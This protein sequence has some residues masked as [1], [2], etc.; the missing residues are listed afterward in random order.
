MQIRRPV[1]RNMRFKMAFWVIPAL[2][3]AGCG[4][5][6]PAPA[7]GDAAP[8]ANAAEPAGGGEPVR[9]VSPFGSRETL[10]P[11]APAEVMAP[12]GTVLRVRL[13]RPIDTASSKP[14][15]HFTAT[16]DNPVLEGA[17]VV[18]P[19]GTLFNGHLTAAKPSGRLRGRAVLALTLES[20]EL[21]GATHEIAASSVTR[22]G[23]D[24]KRRNAGLI[25]GGAG[26]G[27]VLGAIA[28]GAKGA[29]LGAGA[30]AAAGTAGAAASGGRHVRLPAETLLV[31]S[32]ERPVAVR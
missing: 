30:G 5:R 6:G 16:L 18:I 15:D 20:F 22:S 10:G 26:L 13:T 25:G 12:A 14:G 27:A 24:H 17:R 1:I 29:L 23:G 2:L 31:F 19:R 21:R 4:D 8:R 28:G 3:A 9:A 7:A 32:L 11:P